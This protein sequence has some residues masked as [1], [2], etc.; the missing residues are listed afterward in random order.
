MKRINAKYCFFIIFIVCI[1]YFSGC[2]DNNTDKSKNTETTYI[3]TES[4]TETT[5]EITTKL[6]DFNFLKGESQ[7][8][9]EDMVMKYSGFNNSDSIIMDENEVEY[10]HYNVNK[11]FKKILFENENYMVYYYYYSE[12]KEMDG[13]KDV[14]II[15]KKKKADIPTMLIPHY[16]GFDTRYTGEY[17]LQ[18]NILWTKSITRSAKQNLDNNFLY[19]SFNPMSSSSYENYEYWQYIDLTGKNGTFS[20]NGEAPRYAIKL[21]KNK[22]YFCYSSYENGEYFTTIGNTKT[23]EHAK[24]KTNNGDSLVL[25]DGT[26]IIDNAYYINSIF[27]NDN[28]MYSFNFN[29]DLLYVSENAIYTNTDY[30]IL[31]YS[32]EGEQLVIKFIDYDKNA[33]ALRYIINNANSPNILIKGDNKEEKINLDNY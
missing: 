32:N 17:V 23:L 21:S 16:F 5:T 12:D 3:T 31:K 14:Y 9:S 22:E 10:E 20:V 1:F 24:Y 2:R 33:E 28:N 27:K 13:Y 18:G 30:G 8:I 6:S 26:L 29:G 4:T 19:H 15:D 25:D 11:T 7:Y